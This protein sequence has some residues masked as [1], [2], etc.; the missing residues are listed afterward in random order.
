M[1]TGSTLGS[2]PVE[3]VAVAGG[4]DGGWSQQG[5]GP[6]PVVGSGGAAFVEASGTSAGGGAVS[7]YGEATGGDGGYSH[8][9]TSGG[10][11]SPVRLTNAVR[12]RDER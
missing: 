1:A 8:N 3:V 12:G 11:G 6:V 4:G 2:S 10:Q 7:V 9:A 5:V